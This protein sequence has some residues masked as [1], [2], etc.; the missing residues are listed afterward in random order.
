MIR[1]PPRSTLF[2][3]TTLF[4]ARD[5]IDFEPKGTAIGLDYGWRCMEGNIPTPGLSTPCT[6]S[7]TYAPPVFDYDHSGG[8]CAITGGYVVRDPDLGSL[9]G[10]YVYGDYC[11][12]DLHTLVLTNAVATDQALGLTVT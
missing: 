5:E 1:R 9:V 2:P 11:R 3:Y 8:R 6:P 12:G 7:G 10:R 4:R